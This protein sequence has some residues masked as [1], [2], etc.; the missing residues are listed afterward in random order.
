MFISFFF[1]L[2]VCLFV[3]FVRLVDNNVS[4]LLV[5]VPN[6]LMQDG[7]C[8]NAGCQLAIYSILTEIGKVVL[9]NSP[10]FLI[11]KLEAVGYTSFWF[12]T[13]FHHLRRPRHLNI[14]TRPMTWGLQKCP[15]ICLIGGRLGRNSNFSQ[16]FPINRS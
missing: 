10:R 4:F 3:V 16:N 11:Y 5:L 13:L 2:F 12:T 7:V 1:C 14:W 8:K 6:W 9:I 15:N